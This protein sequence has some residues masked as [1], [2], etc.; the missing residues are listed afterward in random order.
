MIDHFNLPVLNLALSRKFYEHVLTPLGYRFF[1]EDGSAIG[2]G[3]DSW[4]FGI[5]AVS[6]PTHRLHLAFR[7][8][9]RQAVDAFFAA[10]LAAGGTSN[11]PPGV[12]HEYDPQYYA[13]F[14]LDPDGHNLEAVFRGEGAV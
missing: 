3:R 7:A 9:S 13:A 6:A 11:G 5:V 10:A 4:E 1:A 2:F 14:V 12:R 8:R